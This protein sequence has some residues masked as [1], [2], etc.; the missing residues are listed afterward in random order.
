MR[1]NIPQL[2]EG[3]A[4]AFRGLRWSFQRQYPLGRYVFDFAFLRV[5]L[6]V[7]ID[8]RTYHKGKPNRLKAEL[9]KQHGFTLLR[10]RS[11]EKLVDRVVKAVR[12]HLDV[13]KG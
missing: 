8:G 4:N 3:V 7:E 11:G 10:F 5:K 12:A 2:E 6:L 1:R 9:A 13:V